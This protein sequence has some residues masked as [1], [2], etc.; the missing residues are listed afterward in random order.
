MNQNTPK[1]KSRLRV[2]LIL[3]I[4]LAGFWAAVWG[5]A[6]ALAP[7]LARKAMAPLISYAEQLGFGF[8]EVSFAK[9]RVFPLMNG[10][11]SRD[12]RARFDLD[13]RN[14]VQLQSTVDIKTVALRLNGLLEPSLRNCFW[15]TRLWAT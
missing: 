4:F 6:S 3:L 11:E 12:M 14:K 1:T 9:L 5:G 15:R 10:L 8:S 7:G 2:F 13:L